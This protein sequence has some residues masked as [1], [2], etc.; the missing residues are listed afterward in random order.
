[1]TPDERRGV[2]ELLAAGSVSN[3]VTVA[4]LKRQLEHA[5]WDNMVERM[6]GGK[7]A[8]DARKKPIFDTKCA[9]SAYD[10]HAQLTND[11]R[12]RGLWIWLLDESKA[13]AEDY[14]RWASDAL[15]TFCAITGID[16]QTSAKFRLST[17]MSE[18]KRVP[19]AVLHEA[20]LLEW[21]AVQKLYGAIG[22]ALA[23]H[24]RSGREP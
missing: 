11:G 23:A 19:S 15:E 1:M 16:D 14:D 13:R 4:W 10:T 24:K 2:E 8:H 21:P 3:P 22:A 5:D 12:E 6:G 20:A 17:S 18:F 7:K 9:V